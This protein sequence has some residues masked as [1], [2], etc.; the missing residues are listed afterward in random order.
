MT[1][2][3]EI[4]ERIIGPDSSPTPPTATPKPLAD[5]ILIPQMRI[6]TVRY[7]VYAAILLLL[8]AILFVEWLPKMWDT[9][10]AT[11]TVYTQVQSQLGDLAVAKSNAER[12]KLYL[13]EIEATQSTLETCLN[14]ED[15]KMCVA[16]PET[17]NIT[18]C[19]GKTI[20]DF[21][22]PLSYLQLH[23]LSTPKMPIDEKKVLRNLN[24]YLIRDGVAQGVSVKNGDIETITI[25]TSSPVGASSVFF[26]VPIEFS[27]KF[28]KVQDLISFVRNVEKKL[29]TVADDRILYKVQEV[30]Y[31]IVASTEPQTADISM[32]AYYYHDTRF[33]ESEER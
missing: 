13:E 23:S 17:W 11:H 21:S 33:Q 24:E 3:N 9:F 22:I 25:G 12:N 4:L 6:V 28:E 16:L 15:S 1:Q 32:I 18:T 20:K 5:D 19:E 27:I 7:K 14:N 26:S 30:G 29:I 31:D 2:N 10:R 8:L